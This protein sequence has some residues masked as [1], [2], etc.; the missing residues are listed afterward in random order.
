M[1]SSLPFSGIYAIV[2]VPTRRWYVGQAKD[3]GLRWAVHRANLKSGKHHCT[4]L[5]RTYDKYGPEGFDWLVVER[6]SVEMLD[7]M[8]QWWMDMTP[9]LFNAQ[10]TAGSARGYRVAEETKSKMREAA[11]RIGSDP[12]E[13]KRRSERAKEQ[14][15]KGNIGNHKIKFNPI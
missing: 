1:A 6:C 4:F 5:Q 10:P 8:E 7:E 11:K 9:D 2:H 13:R 12:E 14:W 15:R 3:I